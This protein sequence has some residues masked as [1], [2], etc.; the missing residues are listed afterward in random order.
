MSK[1]IKL[2]FNIAEFKIDINVI[3]YMLSLNFNA[4]YIKLFEDKINTNSSSNEEIESIFI[5]YM[6]NGDFYK[7]KKMIENK[8]IP[9][10][11]H[12]YYLTPSKSYSSFSN[13]NTEIVK[14]FSTLKAL[15]I[16]IDDQMYTHLYMIN[17]SAI[18]QIQFSDISENIN[19][20]IESKITLME[21]KVRQVK[22]STEIKNMDHLRKLF[23]YGSLED[24]IEY[25]NTI[26]KFQ[27][28]ELCFFNSLQNT[29]D[30]MIYVFN[31]Y[32]Y[33]P[34][35]YDIIDLKDSEKKVYLIN[36]FYGNCF[37]SKQN[38]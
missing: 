3:T 34:T 2:L 10:S 30:V 8:F 7:V 14:L 24:I 18:R 17:V 11:Q 28:D 29:Y 23:G 16:I 36:R 22:K 19:K 33:I 15:G 32:A 6:E 37:T 25:T 21:H 13:N 1:F 20:I 26:N 31:K 5:K 4:K 38:N 27:P 35:I 12:L 9:K